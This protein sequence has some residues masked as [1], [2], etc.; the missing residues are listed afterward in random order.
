[1]VRSIDKAHLILV[2]ENSNLLHTACHPESGRGSAE[3]FLKCANDLY[4][5]E[6]DR[7]IQWLDQIEAEIPTIVKQV[8]REYLMQIPSRE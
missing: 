1:M 3:D 8:R 6:G 7:V 5:Y 4:L 2:S